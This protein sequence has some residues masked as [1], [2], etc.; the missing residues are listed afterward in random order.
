MGKNQTDRIVIALAILLLM[1]VGGAYYF[2]QWMWGGHR[3]RGEK[4]GTITSQEGDV[5]LKYQDD[6]KWSRAT[7]GQDL[8]YDDAVYA[9][10]GSKA[11]LSVGKSQMTVTENSLVVLRR[12]QDVS[13]LNLNYGHIF[14]T[15]ARDE[16]IVIDTGDGKRVEL[17]ATTDTKITVRRNNGRTQ[18]DV[19][20]GQA[21]INVDGKRSVITKSERLVFNHETPAQ[22]HRWTLRAVKPLS[23]DVVASDR[24]ARLTFAWAWENGRKPTADEDYVIEFSTTPDFKTIHA[25]K[26]VHAAL[27]TSMSVSQSLSL[28]YRVRAPGGEVSQ[29]ERVR[30]VRLA[31]PEILTPLAGATFEVDPRAELPV[32]FTF[33][34]DAA[35]KIKYQVAP[36]EEFNPAT[37]ER[38]VD[39]AGLE[40]LP[41]G[42]YFVRA[43]AEYGAAGASGWTSARPF[44]V[45]NRPEALPLARNGPAAHALIPN[46][47]Y[48]AALYAAQPARVRRYLEAQGFLRRFFAAESFDRITVNVDGDPKPY[49]SATPAWPRE[50]LGPGDYGYTY[51]TEKKGFLPSATS[52]P[53]RLDIA[54]EPPRPLGEVTFGER[55]KDGLTPAEW[56]F[57]PLLFARSYDV[58]IARTPSFRDAKELRVEEARVRTNLAGGRYFWRARGRDERGR[59]ISAFSSPYGL[60]EAPA[61]P[62]LLAQRDPA[63]APQT[64]TRIIERTKDEPGM[65]NGWYAWLGTGESYIKYDQTIPGRGAAAAQQ[66]RPGSQYFEGGY[67]SLNGFGGVIAYQGIP[68]R[69]D[70]DNAPVAG[71]S[72]RWTAL[73]VDAMMRKI[74]SWRPRGEPVIYGARA[75]VGIQH[76]PFLFLDED[77][78]V[79]L[80]MN[81]LTNAAVGVLAEWSHARWRY[82]SLL[83]YQMPLSTR[84]DGSSAFDVTS[85]FTF[86]GSLGTSYNFTDRIKLGAFLYGQY[87]SFDFTYV[88]PAITNSGTQSLIYTSLDV[89]LGYEF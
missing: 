33:R 3:A 62:P 88:S 30:F 9:G 66:I 51:Q 34:K 86:N 64:V 20:S 63:E 45:A 16:K 73:A 2:D 79:V 36:N 26:S 53:R 78:N 32:A 35:A 83:R 56:G 89:R 58:E 40:S 69:I 87:Q 55:T 75:G 42:G 18:L 74:S 67:N 61:A 54:M 10:A 5:R 80:R 27:T 11:N 85:S 29:I 43:R 38:L 57:T 71:S 13:F 28:L 81:E 15:V 50:K 19:Q 76:T 39:S 52:A 82:Y 59:L 1:A 22:V 37:R 60:K 68:G 70:L 46:R 49:A 12:D 7:L 47:E 14:G 25:T 4:I 6:L 44:T 48:P 17:E 72:Y 24:P 21:K 84:A 65:H 41:P 23:A 8:A 77:Q 31:E